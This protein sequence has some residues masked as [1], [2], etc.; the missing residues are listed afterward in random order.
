MSFRGEGSTDSDAQV[1]GSSLPDRYPAAIVPPGVG[2][3]SRTRASPR[4]ALM[5]A[6]TE[7]IRDASLAGDL[8][9]ARVALDALGML[10]A[11]QAVVGATAV[12]VAAVVDLGERRRGDR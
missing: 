6:L 9:V 1:R 2:E 10:L 3:S 12:P 4:D 7:A 8:G 11:E 5:T